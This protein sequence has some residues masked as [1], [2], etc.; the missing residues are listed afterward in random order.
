MLQIRLSVP[1]FSLGIDFTDPIILQNAANIR[2]IKTLNSSEESISFELPLNDSK[3]QYVNYLRWWECWDTETNERLNYGPINEIRRVG[4]ENKRIGGPGRSA[5]FLDY[6]KNVRLIDGEVVTFLDNMRYENFSAEPRT[7]TII[8]EAT[9]SD[10]YGLSMRTKD[11]AIDEDTGGLPLGSDTPQR[12][13]RRADQFW[14]GVGK[15][16]WLTVDLGEPY[17]IFKSEVTLPW[18][19]GAVIN[20]SRRYDWQW[21]YSNDNSSW[22]QAFAT[23]TENKISASPY[24]LYS[25]EDGEEVTQDT[26]SSSPIYARYWKINISDTYGWESY[27]SGGS[28]GYVTDQWDW[29]CTHTN[30]RNGVSYPSPNP[31]TGDVIP[32]DNENPVS[33]CHASVIELKIEKRII[34]R[35][36]ISGLVA[37]QIDN[38]NRQITYYHVPDSSEMISAGG[39]VKFE[40]GTFFRKFH[41]HSTGDSTIKDE[42]NTVL[43]DGPSADVN[44]PAYTRFALFDNS[45]AQ[46][47]YVDTWQGKIDAFSY[48]SSYSYTTVLNDYAILRF[49]GVSVKWYATIPDTATAATVKIELR[50]MATDGTWSSWTTLES[51]LVLPTGVAAEKVWEITYSSGD[52]NDNTVY[53]LKITNL[54]DGGWVSI[55]S[56]VG[57]WSAVWNELNEDHQRVHLQNSNNNVQRYENGASFGSIYEFPENIGSFTRV[58]FNFTGDRVIIYGKKGPGYG[59]MQVALFYSPRERGSMPDP[60]IPGGNADGSLT[61]DLNYPTEVNNVVVFDSNDYFDDPGLKWTTYLVGIYKPE[62]PGSIWLD[63]FGVHETNRMSVKF[64]NTPYLEVIKNSTEFLGMEWDVTETGLRIIPRLGTDTGLTLTEGQEPVISIEVIEDVTT[65]ASQLISNGADIDGLPLSTIV[66]NKANKTLIGRTIQR[67]YDQRDNSSY[68]QMIGAARTEL[69]KRK[70]PQRRFNIQLTSCVFVV[71]DSVTVSTPDIEALVRINSIIREQSSSGGTIYS[72]EGE[73]W[74]ETI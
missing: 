54:T 32:K 16:D 42:Y 31:E 29:E 67:E 53:E 43:Y 56:F 59:P 40:P 24:V 61:I 33:D 27:G 1:S 10:Y 4:G 66:E 62:D 63:G 52:L 39:G 13:L 8:N 60:A 68:F 15:S 14:T 44:A 57:H 20:R 64:I 11:Y 41:F 74:L 23:P 70:E 7:S 18:W 6:Y 58:G 17:Y 72:L 50:N 48:G 30:I 69:A 38:N 28:F 21:Y 36:T 35:D 3:Q 2:L 34:A 55:D 19:G 73:E 45:T 37:T 71:G 65:V 9:D 12:G 51:G 26:V 49:R 22:T 47:D 46:I 5:L 25:G